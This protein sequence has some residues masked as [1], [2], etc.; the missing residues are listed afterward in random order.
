MNRRPDGNLFADLAPPADGE[1][2]EVLR[3]MNGAR[4]ERIISSATPQPG[5]YEQDHDEWVVLLRGNAV[6]DVGGARLMLNAGDYVFLAAGVRHEVRET[7]TGAL[8]LAL[9]VDG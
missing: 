2:F 6:L 4:V 1:H 7:S 9:H 5:V 3:A 8:W